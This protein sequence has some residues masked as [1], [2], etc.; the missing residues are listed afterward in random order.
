[1]E[2][3]GQNACHDY[4]GSEIKIRFLQTPSAVDLLS[5]VGGVCSIWLCSILEMR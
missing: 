2:K 4:K 1:M 5:Y 3:E